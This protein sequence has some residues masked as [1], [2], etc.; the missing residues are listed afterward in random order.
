MKTLYLEC[1]MGAAGDMLMSALYDLMDEAQ[2]EQFLNQMNGLSAAGITVKPGR[3]TTCGI[4]GEHLT[5]L[6]NG[7]EEHAGEPHEH[8]HDHEHCHEHEHDHDHEY[9]HEHDHNHEHDH[10]HEHDHEHCHDHDHDHSHTHDAHHHHHATPESVAAAI[11]G[12]TVSDEVKEKA[13]DVYQLIAEAEASAHGTDIGLVHYHEVG[14]MD[15]VADVVGVSLALSIL[16]PDQILCSPINTGTGMIRCAHGIMPV[17]A[18]ATAA[19][20]LGVPTYGD[21][22]DTEL[23][24][25]TGAAL[26]KYYSEAF[27]NRPVMNVEKIGYGVGTKDFDEHAN[28]IRA[29]YGERVK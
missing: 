22:E 27:G 8:S 3:K 1:R 6:V 14:A 11:D 10:D 5:I 23:C 18:P 25:P 17:P 4:S 9:C 19:L 21:S 12:L 26:L 2:K 29:F 7:E 16:N 24:T 28:C 13:K 20:L 15:A